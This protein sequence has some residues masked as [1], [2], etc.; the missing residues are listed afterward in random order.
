LLRYLRP[1]LNARADFN[2]ARR[3]HLRHFV[4]QVDMEQ[5]VDME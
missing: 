1:W 3:G 5:L 2:L 4:N